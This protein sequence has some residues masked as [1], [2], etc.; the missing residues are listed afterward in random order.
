MATAE[1]V[2]TSHSCHSGSVYCSV[3]AAESFGLQREGSM[4][5]CPACGAEWDTAPWWQGQNAVRLAAYI[6]EHDTRV[7]AVTEDSIMVLERWTLT[8]LAG[9]TSGQTPVTL[10]ATWK[11]VRAWLGY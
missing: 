10:P 11:A 1:D 3:K 5:W 9:Q 6:R 8:T 4:L 7:L 2:M